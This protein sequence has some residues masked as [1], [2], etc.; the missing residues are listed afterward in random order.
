MSKLT[1][2]T[3]F[4]K[5]EL[6]LI[7]EVIGNRKGVQIDY[8][9]FVEE[10][11]IVVTQMH[12]DKDEVNQMVQYLDL[13]CTSFVR[14]LIDE[15]YYDSFL[16]GADAVLGLIPEGLDGNKSN[17]PIVDFTLG[18]KFVE[19]AYSEEDVNCHPSLIA[20]VLRKPDNLIHAK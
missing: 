10:L 9:W 17:F 13:T 11:R 2:L 16:D 3:E 18:Y 15:N 4:E 5:E 12:M 20:I 6:D 19:N 14:N 1:K 7:F 8:H